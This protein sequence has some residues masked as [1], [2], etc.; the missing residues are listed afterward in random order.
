MLKYPHMVT[1]N[2]TSIQA[3]FTEEAKHV[4]QQC[5]T[6]SGFL[7]SPKA[8][9]NYQRIWSRDAAIAGLTSVLC[10]DEEGTACFVQSVLSLGASQGE[11]GQL[12]SNV[13][14]SN[15]DAA[16][17]GSLSGRVDATT[18]W[19]ISACMILQKDDKYADELFP[20]IR[21]ALGILD[22]WQYN[23]RGFIYTPLGGNWADEYISQGYVLYD[24][25]LWLWAL[26]AAG[27]ILQDA[28]I[29]ERAIAL[30]ER[31]IR[32]FSFRL[33]PHELHYHLT[34]YQKVYQ[35]NALLWASSFGPSGYDCRWD[36]PAHALLLVLGL[37]DK[38]DSLEEL[39]MQWS[40]KNDSGLLPVFDPVI[41]PEDPEWFLLRENYRYQFKNHPHHFHN[42]GSWPVWM[43]LLGLGFTMNGRSDVA[44]KFMMQLQKNMKSVSSRERF[45][46]YWNP[47]TGEPGGVMPLCFSACGYLLLDLEIQDLKTTKNSI[48]C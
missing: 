36:M 41:V 4:M 43:G 30:E 19:I 3:L 12:P 37:Y 6:P 44:Q 31:I 7:A 13:G 10:N 45:A 8:Q 23:N 34:A 28:S 39:L 2:S 42:G 25:L 38:V 27:T 5:M 21:K 24:Q 48:L 11:H 14:L 1:T 40:E 17:Y 33:P 26:R 16:S 18:W 9:D 15:N 22:V 20:K 46:E 35:P 47:K 32:N 29:K